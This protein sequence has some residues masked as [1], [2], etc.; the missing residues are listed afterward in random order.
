MWSWSF[1][2]W[3]SQFLFSDTTLSRSFAASQKCSQ[4]ASVGFQRFLLFSAG[5]GVLNL[6][7]ACNTAGR[8]HPDNR[9]LRESAT[10]RHTAGS[11]AQNHS[12]LAHG[13]ARLHVPCPFERFSQGCTSGVSPHSMVQGG[14]CPQLFA[15]QQHH[16]I[17][18]MCLPLE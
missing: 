6:L 9:R 13:Q 3:W 1:V 15:A 18:L 10:T 8:Q 4:L 5:V 17:V 12:S 14:S 2:G 7:P 16:S 11:D